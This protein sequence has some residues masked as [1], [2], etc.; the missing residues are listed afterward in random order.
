MN[1]AAKGILI[2]S[3]IGY[4]SEQGQAKNKALATENLHS[5]Q[6]PFDAG[7]MFFKLAFMEDADINKIA[8]HVLA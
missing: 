7:D 2:N 8:S 3:I 4:L 1:T 6:E 5:E